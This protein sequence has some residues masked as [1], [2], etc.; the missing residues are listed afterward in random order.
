MAKVQQRV[1]GRLALIVVLWPAVSLAQKFF[2]DDPIQ[3]IP[4]AVPVKA[5][6]NRNIDPLYDFLYNSARQDP[7]P[8]VPAG[9][10]N[11]LGEVPDSSWFTNRHAREPLSPEQLRRGPGVD[12]A[13]QPPFTVT[14]GK[15][16]GITPGF[17]MRDSAGRLYFVK[18]D[19]WDNPE[20][21]TASEVVVSKFFFAIGYNTPENYLVTLKEADLHLSEQAETSSSGGKSRKMTEKDLDEIL[22]KIP[23][24]PDGSFRILASLAV[25]GEPLGPFR[26]EG[27]R[28]DDPNDVVAHENRRD[29]RG[30]FVFAEWLNHTDTKAANSLDTIV[31]ENGSRF[32]RHHLID[33]G[34]ALGSDS[35]RAKNA[36]FGHE[37][38]I[39]QAG[40]AWRRIVTVGLSPK[41]WERAKFPDLP[42]VG[43]FESATFEPDEWKSNYPNPAF[44]NR[45]P[46]DEFWAAKQV[47]AFTNDD[48]RAMVE[49]GQFS[50]PR[51]V[52]YLVGTLAERR[53]K[54]GRTYFSKVLP[55]DRFRVQDGEL[56]FSDLAVTYG[57]RPSLEYR[58]SWSRFDNMRGQHELLPA[59]TSTRLP[60]EAASAPRASYFSAVITR[61]NDNAKSVTVYVR[62]NDSGY[63]V[64]G[65]ER[66]W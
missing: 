54:I 26:Y 31:E 50:D 61:P 43:H 12:K 1:L 15:S 45:L 59:S 44:L 4:S 56:Q 38:I 35:D 58:I 7:R 3:V 34:S 62:K 28:R 42:A 13:P 10:V 66:T 9:A 14:G 29:L 52:D 49:T 40:D 2:P 33:F 16:E 48:I 51:V 6:G 8:A 37:F 53:D 39:P 24:S 23:H 11:T 21:A 19:P 64:V 63:D 41:P 27:T 55:L 60:T 47:M 32:V 46:D 25:E 30:L 5:V 36:R 20:M 17:R 57:F 18:P 65:I 22:D